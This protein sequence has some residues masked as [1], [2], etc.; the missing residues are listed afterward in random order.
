MSTIRA[1]EVAKH[2]GITGQELRRLLAEVNFGVEPTER[3]LPLAVAQGVVRF[4]GRKFGRLIPPL[5]VGE[6]P[7]EALIEEPE[8]EPAATKAQQPADAA[9]DDA[10]PAA[11]PP[12]RSAAAAQLLGLGKRVAAPPPAPKAVFRKIEVAPTSDTEG[13]SGAQNRRRKAKTEDR[14]ERGR[15]AT[16]RKKPAA[17]TFIKKEGTVE[18]PGLITL[19]EFSE[20][21]GVPPAEIIGTLLKNGVMATITTMLDFETCA[22]VAPDLEVDIARV[23]ESAT[24]EALHTRDVS[25][26][27]GEED[28]ENL[29]PRPPVVVVMGHVDHGKTSLLD[30]I[31][32][33]KVATGESGGITQHIGAY[34]VEK[35]GRE[36]TF[37]DT[38]GHEAFT[39]MRARGAVAADVA[40]LAISAQEGFRPQTREAL[41]HARDA[42]VP[43]VVAITKSDASGADVQKI[44]TEMC[45]EDLQPEDM[46]GTAVTVETSAK[47]GA[48]IPELLDLVLLQA[49]LLEL[50]ADPTRR[51]VATVI[52]SHLDSSL[53]PVATVVVNT[54]TLKKGDDFVLSARAGRIRKMLCSEGKEHTAAPPG[55]PVQI[56]GL[57]A[58]PSVGDILQVFGSKKDAARRAAELAD[59]SAEEKRHANTASLA[60]LLRGRIADAEKTSL[61]LVL[62]TDTE[63][64]L[65]ALT[66][67]IDALAAAEGE[68]ESSNPKAEIVHGAVGEVTE[69]DVMMAAAGDRIVL[70][71]HAGA[72][73]RVRR[74]AGREH[75]AIREFDVIY[76]LLDF[77]KETL[78][79]SADQAK[80]E[81][82]IGTFQVKKIFYTKKDFAILGGELTEGYIAEGCRARAAAPSEDGLTPAASGEI[83]SLQHFE[84]KV[85]KLEAPTECGLRFTGKHIPAEGE[86]LTLLHLE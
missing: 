64:S 24:A 14:R 1:A 2:I 7:P 5:E 75:V 47:T 60:D 37:L 40:I 36:I 6:A 70:G 58:P 85:E 11:P 79:G 30:A 56:F 22:I 13:A 15:M 78:N 82:Q 81:V 21:I 76:D 48:G 50:K 27:V 73:A 84:K 43:L 33:T 39:A 26:V 62:R 23:E 10:K 42:G 28:A 31:R 41:A 38:P 54:G 4:A 86:V 59:L 34:S 61:R 17:A 8:P 35:N 49:D 69:T 57:S 3:T 67:A 53:G 46:G 66:A 83:T 9:A 74:V 44:K 72:S 12:P 65:E 16:R 55:F 80:K 32:K 77:V 63:G 20:K 45:A 52:E 71:F 68:E 25:E 51:A 18:I 19:K 29:R